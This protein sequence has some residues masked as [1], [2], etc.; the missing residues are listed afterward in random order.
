MLNTQTTQP[1]N[2]HRL[3]GIAESLKFSNSSRKREG[4]RKNHKQTIRVCWIICTTDLMIQT[5][6]PVN[7]ENFARSEP[8]GRKQ[9][10]KKQ[11]CKIKIEEKLTEKEAKEEG[12]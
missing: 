9:C 11:K 7:G 6:S 10:G 2:Q 8:E 1:N 4:K 5:T 12:D 3:T